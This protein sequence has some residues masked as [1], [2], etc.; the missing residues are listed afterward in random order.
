MLSGSPRQTSARIN[1]SNAKWKCRRVLI[2]TLSMEIIANVAESLLRLLI[3]FSL[4]RML[5]TSSFRYSFRNEEKVKRF[6]DV[7]IEMKEF[8]H[9]IKAVQLTTNIKTI[10]QKCA[11]LNDVIACPQHVMSLANSPG[12]WSA[13]Y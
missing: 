12:V 8:L 3:M 7:E 4:W 6:N 5:S 2:S 10:G 9:M 1:L 13:S 11:D